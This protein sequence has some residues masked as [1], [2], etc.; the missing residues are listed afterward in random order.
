MKSSVRSTAS[1][2]VLPA[3]TRR[4]FEASQIQLQLQANTTAMSLL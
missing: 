4:R 2:S 1:F 3:I